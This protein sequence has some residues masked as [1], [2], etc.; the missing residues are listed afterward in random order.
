MKKSP[1]LIAALI[2]LALSLALAAFGTVGLATMLARKS[3]LPSPYEQYTRDFD[4]CAVTGST[5]ILQAQNALENIKGYAGQLSVNRDILVTLNGDT[6]AIDEYIA[7]AQ[8]RIAEA[9]TILGEMDEQYQKMTELGNLSEGAAESDLTKNSS[10]AQKR[11]NQILRRL[12]QMTKIDEAGEAQV[13]LETAAKTDYDKSY[14][15]LLVDYPD[16]ELPEQYSGTVFDVTKVDLDLSEE[17]FVDY[18][19]GSWD[20]MFWAAGLMLL[21]SVMCFIGLGN[22]ENLHKIGAVANKNMMLVALVAITLV[23]FVLTNYT[24]LTPTNVS[25][26]INQN[27]YIIVLAC[28]M[29]MCIVSSGNIDLSVGRV[30]GF[31]G[32][33]AAK[34]MIEGDMGTIPAVI[35]CLL[36][37]VAIG[38]WQGFWIAYVR[39]P[40]FIVTLAG[41]LTFYGLTM[42]IL[43]GLTIAQFP[44]LF[45]TAF[46]SFLSD[47]FNGHLFGINLNMNVLTMLAG[48]VIAGAYVA[49]QFFN[50]SQRRKKGYSLESTTGMAIRTSAIAIVIV[51]LFYSLAK[52]RGIPTVLFTVAIVVIIYAFITS[53]TVMGRHLYAMGGNV[54]AARLSGVKTQKMLFLTYVNMGLLAALAGLLYAARLDSGS[55]QAGAGD[56]LYAIAS[57]Y[58]GGASAYGGIGTVGGAVVG[59]LT[60]GVIKNGMSIMGLGQDVQQLVLGLVLLLAVVV[61]IVS[62]QKVSLP[63]LSNIS[64]RR[65]SKHSQLNA[66]N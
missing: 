29:L 10:N 41:Q 16:A 52:A 15:A 47:P 59:A 49:L 25:N 51:W 31:I 24:I 33:C 55:P 7:A 64:R 32:A 57:C 39:I 66:A 21:V 28:G 8:T 12:K 45:R 46:C 35:L 54:N 20:Y 23:F 62:K 9:E 6:S 4:D 2:F 42:A 36:I 61:D 26:I 65:Q 37:G 44:A 14:Y 19:V 38:A 60:M 3:N 48:I 63:F 53:K 30:M 40:A 11:V 50:R 56:E 17:T 34:F 27:A 43:K 18:L 5:Y 13:S 22:R 1:M 58:I